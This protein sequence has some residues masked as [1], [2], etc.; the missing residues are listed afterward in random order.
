MPQAPPNPP[1]VSS[2]SGLHDCIASVSSPPPASPL[3]KGHLCRFPIRM[4][5]PSTFTWC[6]FYIKTLLKCWPGLPRRY[7]GEWAAARAL[8]DVQL[9]NVQYMLMLIM[10]NSVTPGTV[11]HQASLSMGCPRREYWGGLSFPTPGDQTSIS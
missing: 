5:R 9:Y 3:K 10:S 2:S 4:E 6:R 1:R 7:R 8:G 11:A